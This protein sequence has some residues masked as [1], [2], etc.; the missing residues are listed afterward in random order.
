MQSK[1]R[2]TTLYSNHSPNKLLHSDKSLL[3]VFGVVRIHNS[4]FTCFI[5]EIISFCICFLS[6]VAMHSFFFF[7]SFTLKEDDSS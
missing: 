6:R 2:G 5:L 3:I 1:G 7:P 4:I